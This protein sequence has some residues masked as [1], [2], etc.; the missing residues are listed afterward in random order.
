MNLGAR[1]TQLLLGDLFKHGA[2]FYLLVRTWIPISM[3]LF[4]HQ[5][6]PLYTNKYIN[7]ESVGVWQYPGLIASFLN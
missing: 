7:L 3:M 5:T 6:F 4:L 1:T 2:L